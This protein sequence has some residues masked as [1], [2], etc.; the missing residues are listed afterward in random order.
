MPRETVRSVRLPATCRPAGGK[1][2]HQDGSNNLITPVALH[3]Y[4]SS[5]VWPLPGIVK[6]SLL[7]VL[8][9]A[10]GLLALLAFMRRD[11]KVELVVTY[12]NTAPAA[13]WQLLTDHAAEP[14]WLPAFGSVL[15][16][17]DIGG[18]AVWT[19]AAPDRSFSF[20]LMTISAI[21]EQRYERILLRDRQ[22]RNQ[23]WDGRWVFELVPQ[24]SGTQL[25]ITE[26]G[27]SDGFPFFIQQRILGS[28]DT[29]L[30]F[31]AESIGQALKA[32][33]TV[34]VVRSH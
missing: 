26:Y 32:P 15:R 9:V 20:T 27:W 29:F 10:A 13:V 6:Y 31:Y 30:K 23:S 3:A 21:P 22:P 18:H 24:G 11:H 16:E 1:E 25:R 4:A 19:H 17:P 33:T 14:A 34:Q 7:V 8:A 12:Q 28:P 2:R 5:E